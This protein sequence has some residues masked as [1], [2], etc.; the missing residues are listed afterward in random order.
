LQASFTLT[1]DRFAA[2]STELQ[3]NKDVTVQI[4][5]P[6]QGTLT[7][8]DVTLRYVY[9]PTA[10][11]LVVELVKKNSFKARMAPDSMIAQRITDLIQQS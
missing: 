9:S 4:Q 1:P 8:S 7:T 11:Q 2:L 10:Q 6:L 5:D 3:S